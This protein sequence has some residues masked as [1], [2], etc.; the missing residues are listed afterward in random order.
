[1]TEESKN[2]G[3]VGLLAGLGVAGAGAATSELAPRAIMKG[4]LKDLF[5]SEM[6]AERVSNILGAAHHVDPTVPAGVTLARV[7]QPNF[8][9]AGT[10]KGKPSLFLSK[11]IAPEAVAHELGHISGKRPSRLLQKLTRVTSP[12]FFKRGPAIGAAAAGVLGGLT[13]DEGLVGTSA[14]MGGLLAA[15]ELAEEFRASWKG[16]K[17]LKAL[18]KPYSARR[19]FTP[20]LH[21]AAQS[22]PL[23]VGV[24]LGILALMKMNKRR[25]EKA[26]A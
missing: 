5:K 16:R 9:A 2:K 8:G 14:A 25:S 15:P 13:G 11:R 3:R 4:P 7:K 12:E 10:Y 17:Y 6:P 26:D 24:P 18:G 1:M 21:Y 19:L 22:L 20:N 23:A